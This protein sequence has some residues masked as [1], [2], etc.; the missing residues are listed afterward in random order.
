MKTTNDPTLLCVEMKVSNLLGTLSRLSREQGD[1]WGP[2][3]LRP[4][5]GP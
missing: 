5:R 3:V 4:P 1:P 2:L